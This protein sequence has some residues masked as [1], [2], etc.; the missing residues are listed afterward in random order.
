MGGL[1]SVTGF[2]GQVPLHAGLAVADMSAG[3]YAAI[4]VLIALLEREVSGEG[5]WV[6]A[7]MLHSMI[8]MMDFQGARY[9]NDG[10]V[11]VQVGNDHPTSSPM[12]LFQASDGMLN[13]GASGVGNWKPLCGALALPQWL[14]D[15]AFAV[16]KLRVKNRARLN[17]ESQTVFESKTVSHWVA[18][19]HRAGVP[20]GP[21]STVPRM[22]ED[23][24]VLN[25][26]VVREVM[27][28]A[29]FVRSEGLGAMPASLQ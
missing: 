25:S 17:R 10:D 26:R 18:L 21:V 1:M 19:L 9:L 11:P 27:G 4:G 15:P 5:Q 12:G 13:I 14:G 7:S 28:H 16:E 3:L 8:A 20:C 2:P 24:Q 22:F 29:R 6:H 23:Q